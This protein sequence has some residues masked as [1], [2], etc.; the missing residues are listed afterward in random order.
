MRQH[1]SAYRA[2]TRFG[3]ILDAVRYRKEPIVIEKNG[4]PVAVLVDLEAYRKLEAL[5]EEE[6]YIEEYTDERLKEFLAADRLSKKE[7]AWVK[8]RFKLNR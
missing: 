2:R 4:R 3:E 5:Q 1:V 8:K 7:A 6:K